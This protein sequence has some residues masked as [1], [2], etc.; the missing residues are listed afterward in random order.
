MTKQILIESF[1]RRIELEH[2]NED[3]LLKLGCQAKNSR[4]AFSQKSL[5]DERT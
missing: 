5:S 4:N 2:L 1:L 3:C